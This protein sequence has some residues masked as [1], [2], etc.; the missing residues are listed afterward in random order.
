MLDTNVSI[1]LVDVREPYEA[2]ICSIGGI[3]IP[4][5]EIPNEYFQIDKNKMVVVYC[6][7]GMRSTNVI[8]FLENYHQYENVYNLEG[9]IL[10]WITDVDSSLQPY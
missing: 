10:A 8:Q 9:G 3:L 4:M 5:N 7:S 2:E 6:R 1:Q